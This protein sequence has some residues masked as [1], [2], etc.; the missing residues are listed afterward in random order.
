MHRIKNT[1]EGMR[2]F[3]AQYS[4]TCDTL[5][6][7]SR[8][9]ADLEL[10][11]RVFKLSDDV[12]PPTTPLSLPS[13]RIAFLKTS[14]WTSAGPGTVSAMKRASSIL[15]SSGATVS[16]LELPA[17]FAKIPEWHARVLAGEGRSSF[18]GQYALKKD[19]MDPFIVAHVERSNQELSK[20]KL[21]EAYDGISRLR[22]VVDEILSGY[23]AV[24]TPSVPDEAT[25]G[26]VS[27]GT[28]VFSECDSTA[29]YSRGL[30]ANGLSPDRPD[31]DSSPHSRYQY[32]RVWRVE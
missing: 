28:A 2:H 10:F 1:A 13:S 29:E 25:E 16:E 31:L 11:S 18:L 23:D 20:K 8:S 19:L 5:G 12:P 17:E 14:E 21:L 26:L 7:Y 3:Q 27:T 22:P 24:L 4:P 30:N 9:A 15:S 32:S 6:L